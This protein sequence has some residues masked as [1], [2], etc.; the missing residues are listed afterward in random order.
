M[1]D[2]EWH[3]YNEMKR[4]RIDFANTFKDI[5]I[6]KKHLHKIDKHLAQLP[7]PSDK[8]KGLNIIQWAEKA[9]QRQNKINE[10]R[11]KKS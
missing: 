3:F 6:I 8:Y 9:L 7:D 11:R 5:V 10:L 1:S 4:L 2:S